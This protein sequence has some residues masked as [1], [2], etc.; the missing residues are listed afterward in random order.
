[1]PRTKREQRMSDQ[2][3]LAEIQHE[4]LTTPEQ[5]NDLYRCP[6]CNGNGYI[7]D[8][9]PDEQLCHTCSGMVPAEPCEHGNYA[10]HI[11]NIRET[12]KWG[13]L[14]TIWDDCDGHTKGNNE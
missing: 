8:L 14:E 10:P 3:R 11:C 13:E 12:T 5:P 7:G 4:I 9:T 1:M 2:E 6:T